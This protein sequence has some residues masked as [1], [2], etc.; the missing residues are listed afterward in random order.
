MSRILRPGCVLGK[1]WRAGCPR[2]SLVLLRG[3]DSGCWS[4]GTD[5][6]SLDELLDIRTCVRVCIP[7]TILAI[8]P[9]E[10]PSM[11]SAPLVADAETGRE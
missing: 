10:A 4:A 9:S 7:R 8:L 1:T 11:N 3:L 5:D 2:L 6:G